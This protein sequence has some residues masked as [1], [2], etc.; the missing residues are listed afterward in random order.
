VDSFYH[1]RRAALVACH[2]VGLLQGVVA[3]S[4]P[5]SAAAGAETEVGAIAALA[6]RQSLHRRR[7]NRPRSREGSDRLH[8]SPRPIVV[9]VLLRLQCRL[10]EDGG[11]RLWLILA[12]EAA[13]D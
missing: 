12:H 8:R 10:L 6:F 5:G 3:A 2:L 9:L 4:V 11:L 1:R 13:A 7:C